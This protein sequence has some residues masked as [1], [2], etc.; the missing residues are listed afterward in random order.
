MSSLQ[1]QMQRRALRN[2]KITEDQYKRARRRVDIASVADRWNAPLRKW[3]A[4]AREQ[5]AQSEPGDE[6]W[7]EYRCVQNFLKQAFLA[8]VVYHPT[9]GFRVRRGEPA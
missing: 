7:P 9:K 1:R 2:G 4:F 6:A 5:S 3:A 8:E